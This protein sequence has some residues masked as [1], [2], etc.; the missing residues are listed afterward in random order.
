MACLVWQNVLTKFGEN[1]SADLKAV[2]GAKHINTRN[3]ALVSQ[4]LPF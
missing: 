2:M 1:R 3:G 4:L